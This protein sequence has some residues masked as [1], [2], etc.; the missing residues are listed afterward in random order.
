MGQYN[1]GSCMVAK[2]NKLWRR[3]FWCLVGTFPKP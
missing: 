2:M 3:G 1:M